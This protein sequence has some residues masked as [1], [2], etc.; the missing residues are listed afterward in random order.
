IEEANSEN[1]FIKSRALQALTWRLHDPLDIAEALSSSKSILR[2][3]K[4]CLIHPTPLIREKAAETLY[5][6]TASTSGKSEVL[7]QGS[8][9][10]II[11]LFTDQSRLVRLYVFRTMENLTQTPSYIHQI[12]KIKTDLVHCL[13]QHV[14]I[15]SQFDFQVTHHALQ[16]LYQVLRHAPPWSTELPE[17]L[18]PLLEVLQKRIGGNQVRTLLGQCLAE[19]CQLACQHPTWSTQVSCVVPM[20]V[21]HLDDPHVDV[22]RA[23]VCVVMA[24]AIHTDRKKELI[25][26]DVVPKLI[27]I[28][29]NDQPWESCV[30]VLK[31]ISC[32]SED[33]RA[34]YTFINEALPKI[35]KYTRHSNTLIATCATQA[36]EVVTWR[37]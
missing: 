15:Q 17:L 27:T 8:L 16:T 24:L 35:E 30:C 13:T 34:R 7:V 14:S 20:V 36:M 12:C 26:H 31:A 33:Y 2:V 22:R 29:M 32:I 19:L 5:L 3:L 28:L 21:A 11:D 1:E 37:P 6:I 23:M 25:Q 18:T 4:K 10:V 9:K